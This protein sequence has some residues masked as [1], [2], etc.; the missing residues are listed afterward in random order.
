M[1][2]NYQHH[3]WQKAY[4]TRRTAYLIASPDVH[5]ASIS[6]CH[7]PAALSGAIVLQL[8]KA[9]LSWS[10]ELFICLQVFVIISHFDTV[11]HAQNNT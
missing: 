1:G 7:V 4:L 10:R 9:V 8:L 2:H 5:A 6:D 11:L 3:G